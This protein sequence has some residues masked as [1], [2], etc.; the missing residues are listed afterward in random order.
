MRKNTVT[1]KEEILH[2]ILGTVGGTI[3][4]K[5]VL[6]HQEIGWS[7]LGEE[8]PRFISNPLLV[9]GWQYFDP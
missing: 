7:R 9:T 8:T 1:K 4:K 6:A 3:W 5:G 2:C